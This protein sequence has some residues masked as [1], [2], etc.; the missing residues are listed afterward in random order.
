MNMMYACHIQIGIPHRVGPPLRSRLQASL[1]LASP[2]PL[3]SWRQGWTSWWP[4]R[5]CPPPTRMTQRWSHTCLSMHMTSGQRVGRAGAVMGQGV[6][7][8]VTMA[9]RRMAG[10]G[11]TAPAPAPPPHP[12]P[13]SQART[14]AGAAGHLGH[15]TTCKVRGLLQSPLGERPSAVQAV[16][17]PT[18]WALSSRRSSRRR[19]G[20][21]CGGSWRWRLERGAG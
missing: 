18:R 10:G 12:L 1:F 11:G 2:R 19:H 4:P 7:L 5:C 14:A 8:L 15:V 13:G 21:R 9:G 17:A 6:V 20:Q 3:T 16:Q